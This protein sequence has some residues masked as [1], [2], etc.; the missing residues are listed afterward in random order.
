MA[1]TISSALEWVEYGG[2]AVADASITNTKLA[3]MAANT[4]KVRN[5]NSSGAPSDIALATTQILIGN[6]TGFTSAA[7]S[8]DVTMANTGAVTV[9]TLNQSTLGSAAT[10]TTPRTIGGVNF[11]GSAPI[12]LPGVNVAGNQATSGLAAT[13][14]LAVE[15]T[16]VTAVANN[17]A[18]ETVYPTF[19]DGAT[20]TQGL[21]TDTGLNYNPSTG[22][23][24]AVGLT[25]SGDLTVNG[26]NTII[27]STTLTVDDKNIEMGSVATPSDTTADGG[28][29]TLK[30]ATDKTILWDNTNDNFT[31]NQD[32][33][34]PTGKVFKINNASTLSATA[35]GSA[36]LASSLT[37]VGTLASP[38][39]TTPNIG[40]PSAGV[41]TNCTAL[42]AAQVAQGTM[43]SG[44]VLVAP[45][46][47]TPA[48]GA[49][50]NCTGLPPAGV[51]GT[52]AI[53]GANTFTADQTIGGF[54]VLGVSNIVHDISTT[55]VA[56]DFSADQLDTIT[57]SATATFTCATYIAG[58]SK[59]IKILDSG[60]GQTLA[61]PAG[62]KFVGTKPTAIVASKTGILTLTCFSTTEASVVA[63]YAEEA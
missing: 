24:S 11:N 45:V 3:V 8:G 60:S 57:V 22:L 15:A 58:A 19:V 48:S 39:L 12:D 47:G 13:A 63:A 21:E 43:A 2:G 28:G 34:I 30:G 62:W 56:L 17:S 38:V 44:M 42:P 40:T 10:L 20:G 46:L 37:S 54:D 33:N 6:G 32:W 35:L 52:A 50:T 41:L 36:V 61:F 16:S 5:A 14:T 9:G 26:T 7:L 53:L 1:R 25:L 59:T 27:N 55:T 49:L 31:S 18:N 29:I 23:L 4:I 51:T